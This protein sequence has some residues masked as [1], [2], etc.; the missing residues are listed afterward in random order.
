MF[1]LSLVKAAQRNL[2]LSLQAMYP[3]VHI[4]LLNVG[5]QVT[6]DDE[7]WNP[8]AVAKKFWVLYSQDKEK[9]MSELDILRDGK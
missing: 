1:S 9:W 5:G 2:V 7:F 6:A 4:V 3:T 8:M